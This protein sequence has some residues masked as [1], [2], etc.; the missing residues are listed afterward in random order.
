MKIKC[1]EYKDILFE[2]LGEIGIVTLN[3]PQSLNALTPLMVH[4]LKQVFYQLSKDS[5]IKVVI[6]KGSGRAFS[7]G[8]DL[9]AM[10]ESLIG[11]QFTQNQIIL[12]G[13]ELALIIR[14]MPQVAMVEIHGHCYTG[15]TEI[16]MFFDLIVAADDAKIG[17]THAKWGIMPTW[18]MTQRLPRLV[19]LN[20]AKELSFTCQ[21]ISGKEAERIGL[22]NRAV[23]LEDLS[24]VSLEMA[25]AI[26]Q[27]SAQTIAALKQL[28]NDGMHTTLEEGLK[29]ETHFKTE[30]TD[31]TEFLKGFK[32]NK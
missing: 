9:N 14:K 1:M 31:R 28:Y 32:N 6:L 27:N 16:M 23:P 7:A 22:V 24:K 21:P 30:I 12:D 5:S 20:K 29:I 26:L 18:G 8:V 13:N 3:R 15:A 2:Q 25:N 11:G 4:E 19:G 17:D 10:N